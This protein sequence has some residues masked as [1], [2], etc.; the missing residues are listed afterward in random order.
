MQ[1]SIPMGL[2][3]PDRLDKFQVV[4]PARFSFFLWSCSWGVMPAIEQMIQI[5]PII[6]QQLRKQG[7]TVVW[8]ARQ[9]SC[10]RNNVYKIF[11][12]YSISTHELMRIS[13]IL[14]FDFFALY[15]QELEKLKNQHE[16]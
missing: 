6:R 13:R 2:L 9:L 15:S 10:S 1:L 4:T 14:D 16:V 11:N 7:H 3:R 8:L 12:N 5:G